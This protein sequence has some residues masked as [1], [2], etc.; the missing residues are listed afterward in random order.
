VIRLGLCCLFAAQPIRFRSLTAKGM[1]KL[2]RPAQLEKI[3]QVCLANAEALLEAVHTVA[4]LGIGAFRISSPLLPRYTHPEVGYSLELLPDGSKIRRRLAAVKRNAVDLGIRLS[5]HPDQFVVLSSPHRDVVRRSIQEL[6]YQALLAEQVGAD[7]INLH[8]GGAYGDKAAALKR[9]RG[10]VSR[11]P[12][13]IRSRL[14]LENDDLSYTPADLL[15]V[16]R[17]L[18]LPLVYDV[19]HHRC[20]PDGLEIE[21]ATELALV[22]W[23][24]AEREPHFHL[25]SPRDGWRG[26]DPRPHHDYIDPGDFPACWRELS[27]TVDVEAKAKELAVLR[28][29][30]GLLAAGVEVWR[31]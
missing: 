26:V 8:A 10:N 24:A 6:D 27:C 23:L 31:R 7:V 20:N 19:H 12:E 11:L 13:A 25:S 4:R 17:E 14:T 30:D 28:L 18:G 21:E 9:L 29:R 22:T 1:E 2:E 16:C 3:S 5:F 15:P